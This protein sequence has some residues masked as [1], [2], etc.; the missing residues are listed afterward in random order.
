MH[1]C[2][3]VGEPKT[4]HFFLHILQIL[5]TLQCFNFF[6]SLFSKPYLSRVIFLCLLCS[7]FHRLFLSLFFAF[8]VPFSVPRKKKKTENSSQILA[9][10]RFFALVSL[11]NVEPSI[12]FF[13]FLSPF[14]SLFCICLSL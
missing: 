7:L 3:A 11:Y 12:C 2:A 10:I 8:S 14:Y 13:A 5:S 6:F 9:S 4:N 1:R